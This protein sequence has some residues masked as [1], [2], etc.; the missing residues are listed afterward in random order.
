M[1]RLS[2]QTGANDVKVKSQAPAAG[3]AS[4]ASAHPAYV[5]VADWCA[6]SGMGRTKTYEALADS[7][8]RAVKLGAKTL[9][10]VQHGLAW[11]ASL[12][13]ARI[14]MPGRTP[15]QHVA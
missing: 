6:L 5:S 11:L 14:T 8:L 3:A 12:P 4:A 9:I 15:A 10:D 13:A 7:H 1:P 2:K